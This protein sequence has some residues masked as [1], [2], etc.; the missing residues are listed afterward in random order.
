MSGNRIPKFPLNN[1][2]YDDKTTTRK[3]ETRLLQEL[4]SLANA[5]MLQKQQKLNSR[6]QEG[7]E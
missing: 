3:D 7:S 2:E 1:S 4:Q 6:I 5:E